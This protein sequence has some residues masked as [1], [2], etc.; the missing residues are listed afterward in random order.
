MKKVLVTG[1]FDII[2]P[3]H[4]NLISQARALG[5]FLVV[6]IA[7]D[8][9]VVKYKNSPPFF[10]EEDRQN[11]LE[12]YFKLANLKNY[13]IVQGSLTDPFKVIKEEQPDIIAL[14]YDQQAYVKELHEYLVNAPVKFYIER[15][16]A[17]KENVC[18]GKNLRKAFE[19][20]QDCSAGTKAWRAGFL[21]INKEQD[22]TSHDVVAKLRS[23]LKIKQIGHTGTLDPFATGLLICAIGNATKMGGLFDLLPKTYVAKIKLGL[24]SDTYDR[25]GKMQKQ[26]LVQN[27]V[28]GNQGTKEISIT[29]IKKVL[30]S[31]IGKQK[32][33]PPMYSAK[34]VNGKKLY[35]LA[36][37]GLEVERQPSMIEIYSIKL[38]DFKEDI[39][40]IEVVCSSGT[41][42]RTLAYDFGQKLGTGA[43]LWKLNRTEIGDFSLENSIKLN[44]SF[45]KKMINSQ[46]A[47]EVINRDY[48]TTLDF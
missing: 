31:F 43:V 44:Q 32:Q 46:A 36:R 17:F 25:T 29:E 14:G 40:N 1:T 39:L 5:D 41:Y 26:K 35:Q 24:V 20:G 16:K 27:K 22:W 9:N 8:V 48:L 3:G 30:Q 19:D 23:I 12:A 13:K 15:L 37:Q 4:L 7:R 34:K 33:L 6:V 21:L 28:K 11:N 2:H 42:I 38:L 10:N 47:L 45:V 18:K